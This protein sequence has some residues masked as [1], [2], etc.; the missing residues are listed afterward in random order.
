V[1]RAEN[2]GDSAGIRVYRD[3]L[4]AWVG[5]R[6]VW[7]QHAYSVTNVTDEAWVPRTSDV[8]ANWLDPEL[9]NFRQNVLGALAS[10]E[11]PDLTVRAT[12]FRCTGEG[13]LELSLQLCNRG[14]ATV[15]SGIEVAAYDDAP[16]AGG[17]EI[18][19]V[20]TDRILHIGDCMPLTCEWPEPH[21]EGF[22]DIHV[23]GDAS[24]DRSECFEGNN[25]SVLPDVPG[26]GAPG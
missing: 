4:D 7:N 13:A 6:P 12:G 5:S 19:R 8:D 23:V 21:R 24:D 11:A 1:C 10:D 9:N 22:R 15:G 26:C 2:L 16:E 14:T 18:C 20:T 3:A 25:T 17:L